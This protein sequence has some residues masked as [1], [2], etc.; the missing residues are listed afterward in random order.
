MIG[1][2]KRSEAE[3][4]GCVESRGV[5]QILNH[6]DYNSN[7]MAHDVSL[8]KLDSPINAEHYAA[9][10]GLDA[11]ST[12][13]DAGMELI[14]AGWGTTSSGG[15]LSDE[16]MRVTVPIVSNDACN[17]AYG[18]GQILD[19][20]VCAGRMG[21]GGIDSCQGD[22]GGPLFGVSDG[23]QILTGVVSWGQGCALADYPGVY[24]RVSAHTQWICQ[25]AGVCG[26]AANPSPLPSPVVTPTTAPVATPVTAPTTAPV[27]TP[28]D[29][30]EGGGGE[31]GGD[32]TSCAP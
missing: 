25:T 29:G 22:S 21:V 16:A 30:T 4:D 10:D 2:H 15:S 5:A 24:T 17:Q 8:L 6:P 19:G 26:G 1:Q 14:V 13:T 20:M 12:L 32:G 3:Q 27:A 23:K 28:A 9:I 31:G 11:G 7:T 18:Q